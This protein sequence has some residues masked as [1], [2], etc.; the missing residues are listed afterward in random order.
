MFICCSC[1]HESEQE[2]KTFRRHIDNL[3]SLCSD[4]E[5]TTEDKLWLMNIT[6]AEYYQ[7]ERSDKIKKNTLKEIR[8]ISYQLSKLGKN[9]NKY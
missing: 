7:T 5:F 2:M 3:R 1:L 4:E 6:F 8:Q 9:K